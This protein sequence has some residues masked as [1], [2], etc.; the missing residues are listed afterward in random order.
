MAIFR[1]RRNYVTVFD[2][3]TRV[4]SIQPTHV[5]ARNT[6][7]LGTMASCATCFQKYEN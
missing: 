3:C 5:Q 4:L 2:L 6:P 1:R 7:Q